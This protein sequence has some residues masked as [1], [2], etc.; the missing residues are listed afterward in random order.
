MSWFKLSS[1]DFSGTRI[2]YSFSI[3]DFFAGKKLFKDAENFPIHSDFP[4][5]A[6]RF[7]VSFLKEIKQMKNSASALFNSN[8]SNTF[9]P[10]F[11]LII[12]F[13]IPIFYLFSLYFKR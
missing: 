10:N 1:I 7:Y 12:F 4:F 13:L 11:Y 6:E 8:F 2:F 5:K 9:F 3:N